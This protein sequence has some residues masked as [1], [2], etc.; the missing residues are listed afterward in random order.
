M[1]RTACIGWR[2][3]L[4]IPPATR[5]YIVDLGTKTP[6]EWAAMCRLL[7]NQGLEPVPHIGAR[8]LSRAAELRDR[9]TAMSEEAGVRDVLLIAGE[10]DET[11]PAFDSSMAVL[12]TGLDQRL[13]QRLPKRTL[14]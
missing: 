4:I 9:L 14:R 1:S 2:S 3:R 10:G 8:R 5:T 7:V 12:E 6:Q 11:A 13:Y